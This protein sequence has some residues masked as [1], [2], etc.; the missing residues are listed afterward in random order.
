MGKAA[1]VIKASW[2]KEEDTD[3][4]FLFLVQ[5]FTA[6]SQDARKITVGESHPTVWQVK[7]QMNLGTRTAWP[8]ATELIVTCLSLLKLHH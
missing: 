3:K 2:Y 8:R 6:E 4:W 7:Y 5:P 1:N